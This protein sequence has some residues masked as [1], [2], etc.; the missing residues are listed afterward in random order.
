MKTPL[1]IIEKPFHAITDRIS[2]LDDDTKYK[3]AISRTHNKSSS[4]TVSLCSQRL[5]LSAIL[6]CV[7]CL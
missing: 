6:H 7:G 1:R 3:E 5:L 4:Q 2:F